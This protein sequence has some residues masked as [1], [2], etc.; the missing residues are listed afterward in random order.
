MFHA[1]GDGTRRAIVQR[2]AQ[3]PA[4]VSELARPFDMAL[5]S[6]VQHLGVLEAA[7][8]VTSTK[9]GRVRT[10]Q[11]AIEALT[12]AADWIGHQRLPAEQRLD[13]LGTFL[14]TS[15]QKETKQ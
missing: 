9:T 15:T 7:G 8:I 13:R 11:L 5:P 2:L 1:L 14:A 3:G 12:P 6:V 4:S 10:Y